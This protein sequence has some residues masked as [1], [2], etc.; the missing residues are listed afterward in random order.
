MVIFLHRTPFDREG[1]VSGRPISLQ[2]LYNLVMDRGGY[3]ALSAER[4]QWRTLVKEFGFGKNHEA[5]MTFQL[6]T[7]Y[8]KNL[9][10]VD[11][12]LAHCSFSS[13]PPL[14]LFTPAHT[15]SRR[16]GARWLLL[17]KSLKTSVP[18]VVTYVHELL[19][20]SRHP[21]PAPLPTTLPMQTNKN[22]LMKTS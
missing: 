4:M 14:T 1:K 12:N 6:K 21:T 16:T 18:R 2:K 9:A 20:A 22:Q 17:R 7:V 15:R 8:Y 19:R 13:Q 10:Y 11:P 5:V 3:D